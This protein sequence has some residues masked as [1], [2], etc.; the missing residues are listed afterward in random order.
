MLKQI[1]FV[2]ILKQHYCYLFHYSNETIIETAYVF[3]TYSFKIKFNSVIQDSRVRPLAVVV[4]LQEKNLE[5][6]ANL[7]IAVLATHFGGLCT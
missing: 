1:P 4:F 5:F 2:Q 3:I 7:T 6:N